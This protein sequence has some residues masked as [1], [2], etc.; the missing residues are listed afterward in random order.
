MGVELGTHA[1]NIAGGVSISATSMFL[2]DL[3]Y[4]TICT[5]L[6]STDRHGCP[7]PK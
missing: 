2:L 4:Q 7:Y 6:N 3:S 5:P 1:V